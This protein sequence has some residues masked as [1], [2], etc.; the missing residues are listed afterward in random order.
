MPRDPLAFK[1]TGV[2]NP[3]GTA[4]E[5][6]PGIPSRDI[7]RS[8]FDAMTDEEKAALHASPIHRPYGAADEEAAQAERR[9]ERE[10]V[11][12]APPEAVSVTVA[13][14]DKPTPKAAEAKK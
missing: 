5:F 11:E 1:F 9:I 6:I 14:A 4:T 8:E 13:G 2:S 10:A 3:D 12:Q 7:H